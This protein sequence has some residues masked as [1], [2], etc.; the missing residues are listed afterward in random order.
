MVRS[1]NWLNQQEK[2]TQLYQTVAW[3]AFKM[4]DQEKIALLN[5]I[6]SQKTLPKENSRIDT[7]PST[8]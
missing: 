8:F 6:K 2:A 4:S 7:I 3:D 5:I 1:L